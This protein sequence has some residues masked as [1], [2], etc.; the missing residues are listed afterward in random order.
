MQ[1]PSCSAASSERL[2]RE[3]IT[4]NVSGRRFETW[5]HTLK[6]FP[7]TLLGSD[8]MKRFHNSETGEY[9]L[10]R[11]PLI[12]KYVLNF[13]RTGK[14]HCYWGY[15]HDE[16]LEELN[17]Y[18][19]PIEFVN[20]CC[21]DFLK[22][23]KQNASSIKCS[24]SAQSAELLYGATLKQKVW[25]LFEYPQSSVTGTIILYAVGLF[26][27]ASVVGT[28]TETVPC[29]DVPC[30]EKYKSQFFILEGICVGAFTLEFIA[31][32][33]AAP[34]RKQFMKEIMNVIDLVAII[35][36]YIS[37]VFI[38]ARFGGG[39]G[40]KLLAALKVLR[41]VR[42]F[43]LARHSA[44]LR[45][46]GMTIKNASSDLA[47]L[48]F[49]LFMAV[50]LFA[51]VIYFAERGSKPPTFISIVD[52]MWYTGVTIITLGYGDVVPVTVFG[53]ILGSMCCVFG[54]FVVSLVV[55]VIQEKEKS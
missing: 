43:K 54:L 12:F 17:F 28:V 31:R 14:L 42:V 52:A 6:R 32:L 48:S 11:D 35:P 7:D 15:C 8:L 49:A 25:H 27:L 18:G 47:F 26:I 22:R 36:F 30:G 1:S 53:K 40:F 4:F 5:H 34:S 10:N 13:Y 9:I 50:L 23:E 19:I 21:D 39:G 37:L 46:L 2:L 41:V 3:R 16:F 51:S 45:Q 20:S 29:P 33:W 38:I 55:P 44:K 24:K